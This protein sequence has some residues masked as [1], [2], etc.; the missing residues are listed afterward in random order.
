MCFCQYVLHREKRSVPTQS[1]VAHL[2]DNIVYSLRST[3]KKKRD[4]CEGA[5]TNM[6]THYQPPILMVNGT[7]HFPKT[8]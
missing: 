1:V 3:N 4:N 8:Y 7:S 5:H 6:P 2:R